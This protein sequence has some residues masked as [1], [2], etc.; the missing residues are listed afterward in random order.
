[1]KRGKYLTGA[2]IRAV[3]TGLKFP[4]FET[5]HFDPASGFV[6][7]SFWIAQLATTAAFIIESQAGPAI[8]TTASDL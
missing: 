1:M 4:F 7:I 5:A 6:N 3:C 2:V 8:C